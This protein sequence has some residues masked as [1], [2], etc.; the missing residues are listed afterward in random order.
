MPEF[1][2]AIEGAHA[3]DKAVVPTLVIEL[4]F[5]N[6][7]PDRIQT[8]FLQTP[9]DIDCPHCRGPPDENS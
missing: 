7:A 2:F 1:N 3:A 9:I 8:V 6:L 4:R 5:T